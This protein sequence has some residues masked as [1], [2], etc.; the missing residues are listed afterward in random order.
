MALEEL[1]ECIASSE[2]IEAQIE[3]Q[4]LG[5]FIRL[6]VRKLPVREGNIFVRRYFFTDSVA[7]I[8]KRYGLS[9]NNVMVILSRTRK[10]LRIQLIKE[11][12]L[13]ECT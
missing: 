7:D 12:F 2:N 1:S 10:K 9:E 8:A 11:G 3:A 6:F 4:N 13:D 5:E